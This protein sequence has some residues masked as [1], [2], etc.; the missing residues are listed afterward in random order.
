M[1]F[2]VGLDIGVRLDDAIWLF[3]VRLYAVLRTLVLARAGRAHCDMNAMVAVLWIAATH[4]GA[5]QLRI[6]S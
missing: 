5:M 6:V 3:G 4:R 2:G 1:A